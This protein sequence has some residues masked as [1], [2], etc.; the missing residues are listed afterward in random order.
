[1]SAKC[2]HG[3]RFSKVEHCVSSKSCSFE[4]DSRI[5]LFFRS[6]E[7]LVLKCKGDVWMDVEQVCYLLERVNVVVMSEIADDGGL[8]NW[9]ENRSQLLTVRKNHIIW[10]RISQLVEMS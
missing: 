4:G 6:L 8:E 3:F 5:L 7:Q 10:V 1:M 2:L 9:L